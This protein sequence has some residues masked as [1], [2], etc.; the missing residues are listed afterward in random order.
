[1]A[2][3]CFPVI[4]IKA[5]IFLV[6]EGLNLKDTDKKTDLMRIV[7]PISKGWKFRKWIDLMIVGCLF[8]IGVLALVPLQTRA[9]DDGPRSYS[10]AGI[11]DS[12]KVDE[13]LKN[14]QALVS[15][16]KKE[17]IAKLIQFP[18]NIKISGKKISLNSTTAFLKNYGQAFNSTV[19]DAILKQKSS[20]LFVN[21]QG[22]MIGNGQI[23]F[24]PQPNG[25]LKIV[26]INN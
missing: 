2:F 15:M 23:W 21:W 18:I 6:S 22:V 1:M 19:K 26:A 16:D 25:Q 14:L 4:C 13:F 20:D 8:W 24:R 9:Q 3:P 11:D 17:A 7:N 10:I 12:S 5:G